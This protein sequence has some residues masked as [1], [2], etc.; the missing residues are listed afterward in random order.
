[1]N[2]YLNIPSTGIFGSPIAP[3][4]ALARRSSSLRP[5]T[6]NGISGL[7]SWGRFIVRRALAARTETSIWAAGRVVKQAVATDSRI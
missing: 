6:C 4:N 3:I 1:M 5:K 7:G 2:I